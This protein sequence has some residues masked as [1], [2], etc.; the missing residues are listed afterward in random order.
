MPYAEVCTIAASPGF[1]CASTC[2]APQSPK[3]FPVL[4]KWL[5]E[6]LFLRTYRR[7]SSR[8]DHL[9]WEQQLPPHFPKTGPTRRTLKTRGGHETGQAPRATSGR[10]RPVDIT[11]VCHGGWAA[12]R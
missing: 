12:H 10:D 3:E 7:I 1:L 11:A 9:A 6:R 8:T 4:R 2:R 5:L